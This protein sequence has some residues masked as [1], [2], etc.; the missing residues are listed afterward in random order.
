V[1]SSGFPSILIDRRGV[2]VT[3]LGRAG[4]WISTCS[5][6][7]LR[8]AVGLS[9][10]VKAAIYWNRPR[11]LR[12]S[13]NHS[14]LSQHSGHIHC[15]CFSDTGIG[16]P[17][18]IFVRCKD[19]RKRF[20]CAQRS[21]ALLTVKGPPVWGLGEGLITPHLNKTSLLWNVTQGFG[22]GGCC[23]HGNEPSGSV[24]GGEFLD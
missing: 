5:E 14:L 22:I 15:S 8:E 3:C 18:V 9:R 12:F 2:V 24:K 19:E 13:V 4:V 11:P 7:I 21:C 23:E 17:A 10:H 6:P 20:K 16:I 1:V